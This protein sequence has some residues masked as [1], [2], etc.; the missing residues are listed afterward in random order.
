MRK[1]LWA[2]P[3]AAGAV[4][5][6]ALRPT[7][8]QQ[9]G[10]TTKQ[11]AAAGATDEQAV[12]QAVAAYADAFNKADAAGI[13]AAWA[14]DAEYV[15]E[16][17]KVTKG[18]DA[19]ANLFK[20]FLGANKGAKM[21]LQVTSLRV[22]K[23]DVALVDGTATLTGADGSIDDGRFTSVWAKADG[24]WLVQ[25]VRDLPG[26]AAAGPGAGGALKD[27]QWLLGT[28]ADEKGMVVVNVR[29]ALDRAYLA[30]DY[31]MKEGD[32]QLAVMQLVGFDPLTGL[33][34][35]WTFDSRGGYG[36]GLWERQ[37]NAW[38]ADTVGVLPGGQVGSAVNV[39]KFTDDQTMTFVSRDRE[40][41]GQPLPDGEV[42]LVKKP[43]AK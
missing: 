14:T 39:L 2:V 13:I 38:V 31:T 17:G 21:A 41:E 16:S 37:G 34:K 7:E 33:I 28:W 29:W 26:E 23:G 9:P 25:T 43:A 35:S 15:D 20:Q 24:K 18:R 10:T 4:L 36:E 27:L 3:L 22:L 6:V 11:P 40:V 5:F 8:G 19:V 42:K 12:R 1:I 32:G 30:M